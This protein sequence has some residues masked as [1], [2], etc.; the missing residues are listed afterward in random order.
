MR[1]L[2]KM[3]PWPPRLI[4]RPDKDR[5]GP[6]QLSTSSGPGTSAGMMT[7]SPLMIARLGHVHCYGNAHGGCRYW[8]KRQRRGSAER[9]QPPIAARPYRAHRP[10]TRRRGRPRWHRSHGGRPIGHRRLRFR[11]GIGR[12][13]RSWEAVGF[14]ADPRCWPTDPCR[15]SRA[16]PRGLVGCDR[17]WRLGPGRIWDGLGR[18]RQLGGL[19]HAGLWARAGSLPPCVRQAPRARSAAPARAYTRSRPA[20]QVRVTTRRPITSAEPRLISRGSNRQ[21]QSPATADARQAGNLV[22]CNPNLRVVRRS[23]GRRQRGRSCS[24]PWPLG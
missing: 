3:L 21:R 4:Y 13:D 22:R 17:L 23:L 10:R 6:G 5:R 12:H 9:G 7:L 14:R 16:A 19:V 8:L 18:R 11:R 15:R 24:C 1:S 20:H 2:K